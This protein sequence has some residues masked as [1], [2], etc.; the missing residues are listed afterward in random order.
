MAH[1]WN[2]YK[3]YSCNV[4]QLLD[5]SGHIGYISRNRHY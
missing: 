1:Y 4:H 5:F 3:Y 2:T